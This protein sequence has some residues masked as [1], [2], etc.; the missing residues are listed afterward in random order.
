MW[1]GPRVKCHTLEVI[2]AGDFFLKS[3]HKELTEV[4]KG[5]RNV[6]RKAVSIGVK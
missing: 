3:S 5:T 6:H 1:F 2:I 4:S